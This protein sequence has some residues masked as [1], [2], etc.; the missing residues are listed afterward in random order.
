MYLREPYVGEGVDG[1]R[2]SARI[3]IEEAEILPA[4]E[5]RDRCLLSAERWS[6]QVDLLSAGPRSLEQ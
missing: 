6:L 3:D 5:D 2:R 1:A 4:G